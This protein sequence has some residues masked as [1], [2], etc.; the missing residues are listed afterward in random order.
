MEQKC[1][2][3]VN[4][5]RIIISRKETKCAVLRIS[6]VKRSAKLVFPST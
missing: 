2:Y 3:T 4:C 1:H 5:G 6:L